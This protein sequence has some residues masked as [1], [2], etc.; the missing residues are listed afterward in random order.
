MT[1]A[2]TGVALQQRTR[3]RQQ[4]GRPHGPNRDQCTPRRNALGKW[5]ARER[6]C[7]GN[8]A[9]GCRVPR[10]EF[11]FCWRRRTPCTFLKPL[12]VCEKM[13]SSKRTP[14]Q[15]HTLTRIWNT[16]ATKLGHRQPPVQ[17]VRALFHAN[18]AAVAPLIPV[19]RRIIPVRL[20]CHRAR[21]IELPQSEISAPFPP[22]VADRLP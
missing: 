14:A 7:A 8:H 15:E 4:Q 9:V 3:G 17:L 10:V 21:E 22:A 5:E 6:R 1:P 2:D 16:F 20:S 13:Q 12:S 18:V 19:K 11:L